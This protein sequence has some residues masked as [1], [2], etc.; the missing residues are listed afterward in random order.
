MLASHRNCYL[1]SDA[2]VYV[3]KSPVKSHRKIQN[4]FVY[5]I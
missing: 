3:T 4:K 2:K 1:N 5:Q